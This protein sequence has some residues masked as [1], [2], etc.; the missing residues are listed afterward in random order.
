M[1]GFV[2]LDSLL[3]SLDVPF[4]LFFPGAEADA[5][6]RSLPFDFVEGDA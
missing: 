3:Q 2:L 5:V 6:Q 4:D 1:Y